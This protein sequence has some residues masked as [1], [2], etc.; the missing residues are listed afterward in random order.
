MKKSV[1]FS[2][3]LLIWIAGCAT[4]SQ[5]RTT[6]VPT[7]APPLQLRPIFTHWAFVDEPPLVGPDYTLAFYNIE[8][9]PSDTWVVYALSGLTASHLLAKMDIQLVNDRDGISPLMDVSP[10]Q[11]IGGLEFGVLRFVTRPAGSKELSI[12]LSPKTGKPATQRLIAR[13]E[14][15]NDGGDRRDGYYTISREISINQA[16]LVVSFQGWELPKGIQLPSAKPFTPSS[17]APTQTQALGQPPGDGHAPWVQSA[18]DVKET[19]VLTLQVDNPKDGSSSK[20]SLQML[21]DGRVL[22][23][24][25][26]QILQPIVLHINDSGEA[27]PYPAP[28]V[29]TPLTTDAPNPYPI[30]AQIQAPSPAP[31]SRP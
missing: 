30:P 12:R 4:V 9:T 2:S 17:A 24:Y 28:A 18:P 1:L 21:N 31:G 15:P 6:P 8:L 29:P 13:L 22:G 26:G 20:L 25:Q 19:S 27:I 23:L 14:R 7:L 5:T 11:Q 3:L 16:G 10:V